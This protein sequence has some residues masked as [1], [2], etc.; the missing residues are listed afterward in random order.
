MQVSAAHV[1]VSGRKLARGSLKE[2]FETA[3]F[4]GEDWFGGIFA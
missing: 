1:R 3:T 2:S 4:T